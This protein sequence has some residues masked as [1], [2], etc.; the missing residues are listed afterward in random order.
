MKE[1]YRYFLQNVKVALTCVPKMNPPIKM[2]LRAK[3][4]IPGETISTILLF[5]E[6]SVLEA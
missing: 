5:P 2:R 4:I 3:Y 1:K 6:L